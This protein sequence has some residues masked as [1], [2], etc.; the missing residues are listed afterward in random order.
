MG[1]PSK[2]RLGGLINSQ[3]PKQAAEEF[4]STFAI[5]LSG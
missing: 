2:F 1:A 5:A 3:G 4:L